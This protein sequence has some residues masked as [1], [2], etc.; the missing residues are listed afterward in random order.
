MVHLALG[1]LYRHNLIEGVLRGRVAGRQ[2]CV[3]N[4]DRY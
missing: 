2:D 4:Q 3:F 1:V